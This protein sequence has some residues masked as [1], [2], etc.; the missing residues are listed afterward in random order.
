MPEFIVG[1]ILGAIAGVVAAVLAE[2]VMYFFRR[3]QL[4]RHLKHDLR[5]LDQ[6]YSI[7]TSEF[8]KIADEAKWLQQARL[9]W[10]TFA[11]RGLYTHNH[12]DLFMLKPKEADEVVRFLIL[13]HNYDS[14]CEVIVD[15]L[16]EGE[17]LP[18][19]IAEL[20]RRSKSLASGARELLAELWP[21]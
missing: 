19:Q 4:L 5:N 20:S 3:R 12:N 18:A 2:P 8:H 15:Q 9:R 17:L 21:E 11:S 1:M 6:H 16:K 10:T 14:A 7:V 13:T